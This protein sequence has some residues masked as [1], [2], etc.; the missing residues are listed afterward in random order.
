MGAVF[1]HSPMENSRVKN[2]H[3]H[4]WNW[5]H[6]WIKKTKEKRKKIT[7]GSYGIW[8]FFVIKAFWIKS[9]DYNRSY[10][11]IEKKKERKEKRKKIGANN[12]K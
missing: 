10:E 6:L 12:E 3:E 7:L 8:F 2:Q 5:L 1:F 4:D 9:C 11:K